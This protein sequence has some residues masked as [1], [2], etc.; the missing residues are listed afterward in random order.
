MKQKGEGKKKRKKSHASRGANKS[1]KRKVLSID[2]ALTLP[3]NLNGQLSA[4]K[5][6]GKKRGGALRKPLDAKSYISHPLRTSREVKRGSA[7]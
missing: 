2:H 1:R 4:R 6:D 5:D 7:K 3:T